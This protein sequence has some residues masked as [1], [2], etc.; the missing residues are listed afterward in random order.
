MR[1]KQASNNTGNHTPLL[2]AL[3]QP[4]QHPLALLREAHGRTHAEILN[5]CGDE[6]LARK[7]TR[8]ANTYYGPTPY[9]RLRRHTIA[10]IRR[11]GLGL[12]AIDIIERHISNIRGQRNK[13]HARHRIAAGPQPQ[14]GQVTLEAFKQHAAA[15]A[16]T[17][18]T[19]PA[20]PR[21]GYTTR[22]RADG[23]H[24][25]LS[26]NGTAEDI[27]S[28][29]HVCG[30]L[31]ESFVAG[32][33]ITS[34]LFAGIDPRRLGIRGPVP[35]TPPPHQPPTLGALLGQQ[36]VRPQE[37]LRRGRVNVAQLLLDALA[38]AGCQH[39]TGGGCQH[40]TGVGGDAVCG[41]GEP[42]G[43]HGV[44]VQKILRPVVV[45]PLPEATKVLNRTQDETV[46]SCSDGVVRTSTELARHLLGPEWHF[47]LLHPVE[48]PVDLVRSQRFAS[49][50][51]RIMAMAEHPSCAW[52]GCNIPGDDCE[53]HHLQAWR[54][55][56]ETNTRNLATCCRFHN[57][58]NDDDPT[59]PTYRGRLARIDGKVRRIV[60]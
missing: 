59:R 53:I 35:P 34:P 50:K 41:M 24:A 1:G 28:L 57:G 42:C 36:A 20:P 9:T 33:P 32:Q 17:L 14:H 15:V 43:G 2:A 13:W 18:R 12:Q 31:V 22:L 8:H 54:F 7:L 6:H 21:P 39:C 47:M 40:G 25:T 16:A 23:R 52:P 29:R 30:A 51:Q 46:F 38:G 4:L 60:T 37:V 56:G 49:E 10:A 44:S 48:G 3:G 5:L 58:W 19:P 55:G 26:I 11:L 45:I 27:N